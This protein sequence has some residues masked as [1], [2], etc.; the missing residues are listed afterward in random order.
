M[1]PAQTPKMTYAEYLAAEERSMEKHEFL[2]GEVH[3]MSGGT[4]EHGA[5]GMAFG[6]AL[7]NALRDKPCRV[8]SSDVRVRVQAT[9]L[10]AYPDVTVVCGKLVTDTED[11]HAIANP[12]LIVEVLSDS[13]EARD[14]GLKAAHYRQIPSL[15]EYVFVSQREPR[16]EVHRRNEAGRWELLEFEGG[17]SAELASIGAAI[18]LD[19]VYRDPLAAGAA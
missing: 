11:P 5:L 2:D 6:R 10:A 16:I 17:T 15:R 8:F 12:I 19:E 13:T 18:P 14:R 9:G 4:P 7:G 3:A 1:M